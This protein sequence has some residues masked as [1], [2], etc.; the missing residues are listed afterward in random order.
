MHVRDI[1]GS[2]VIIITNKN[3]VDDDTIYYA[4]RLAAIHSKGEGKK[5]VDYTERNNVKRTNKFGNVTFNNFKSI[6]V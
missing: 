1:P 4:A 2:H 5:I 6:E 3:K